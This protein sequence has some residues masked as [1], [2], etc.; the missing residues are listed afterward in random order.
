MKE[1]YTIGHSTRTLEN[2]VRVL[3]YYGIEV[4]VD[5]RHFPQSR[6]NPQFNRETLGEELLRNNIIYKWQ[7]KL[8]GFREG[9][10]K[11]YTETEEFKEG[12]KELIKIAKDRN[13]A[14]MCAEI[15]WLKCHRRYIADILKRQRWK[16]FHIFDETRLDKHKITLKR[17]IRCDKPKFFIKESQE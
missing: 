9:G 5:V 11:K 8:G 14:V 17:K 16:V 6:H 3:K 12:I 4:L 1:I 2:F 13:T 15:V 7:K 10:Y